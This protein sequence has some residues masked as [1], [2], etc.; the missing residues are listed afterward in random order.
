M[1]VAGSIARVS[2]RGRSFSVAA[3]ADVSRK[4][5]G[6]ESAIE[7]NGDG[8]ARVI[9]TRQ[10]WALSGIAVDIND[11]RGDQEFLVELQNGVRADAD[12]FY[13]VSIEYASGAIYSG[14]GTVIE[15][16]EYGSMAGTAALSLAGP[17]TLTKQ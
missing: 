2:L 5:G 15:A 6:F 17:G 4:L 13:A 12:G 1:S 3:D 8:T 7:M 9:K 16:V 11:I 10:G 14:R